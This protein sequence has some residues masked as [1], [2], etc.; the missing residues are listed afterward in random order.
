MQANYAYV[1]TLFLALDP[2]NRFDQLH[3]G[4][5]DFR[6]CQSRKV[7]TNGKLAKQV[8]NVSEATNDSR[9]NL[10]VY[11]CGCIKC[12]SANTARAIVEFGLNLY[13]N[14]QLRPKQW[15]KLLRNQVRIFSYIHI[16]IGLIE[17]DPDYSIV[18]RNAPDAVM[19]S[20]LVQ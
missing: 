16:A 8:L 17:I 14:K 10:W 5:R 4:S 15:P 2:V 11:P 6:L 7:L 20:V 18:D 3:S 1:T 19:R 12:L 9:Q 13:L